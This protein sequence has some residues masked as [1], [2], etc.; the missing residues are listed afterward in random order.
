MSGQSTIVTYLLAPGWTAA[1]LAVSLLK[2]DP[3][4]REPWSI[5][6]IA[7]W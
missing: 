1:A 6:E 2:D 7:R 4:S 5:G 3:D